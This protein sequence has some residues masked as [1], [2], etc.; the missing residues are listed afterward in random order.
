MECFIVFQLKENSL[1][2]IF[3]E[4]DMDAFEKG[5]GELFT[6]LAFEAVE[7]IINVSCW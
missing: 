3:C 2:E 6:N 4:M 7:R 1:V 5:V